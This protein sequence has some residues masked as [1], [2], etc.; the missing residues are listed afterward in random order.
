MAYPDMISVMDM[1]DMVELL[2]LNG[3]G[4]SFYVSTSWAMDHTNDSKRL[5]MEKSWIHLF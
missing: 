5:R 4:W 2:D 3:M 1:L